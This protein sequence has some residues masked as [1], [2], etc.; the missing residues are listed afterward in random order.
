MSKKT[1]AFEVALQELEH[2]AGIMGLSD[3]V[4]GYLSTPQ[5]IMIVNIPVRMDNGGMKFF[6]GYRAQHNSA[7]GPVKGGT[8]FHHEETLDDVKALS[9]WMTI[10]NSLANIPAGGAKGGVAVDPSTLS[11]G[12]LERLCRGY[13][14]AVF[15]M[16]SPK[17]DIPGP[18][19]GTPQQ[20][21]AWFL[22]EYETLAH[23]HEPA[24]F[25]G[26]PPLLGGSLGRD[27]ATGRGLVYSTGELM[28]QLGTSLAGKRVVIQGFGNLGSHA[29]RFFAEAGAVIIAA[30]DVRG[31]VYAPKGID[32]DK[33]F[34]YLAEHRTIAGLPGTDAISNEELLELECDI[35]APCALQNQ[36]T[37][38]NAARIRA[39]YVVEGANGPTT[40]AAEKLLTENG[41]VVLPDIVANV[42]G[43][44][45]AYFE[46]VQDLYYYFWT[47]GE[48]FNRLETI[49]TKTCQEVYAT[50]RDKKVTM[51][52]AAW[53]ISLDRVVRAMRL[54]SWVR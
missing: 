52:T 4:V 49:M 37:E 25:A 35:L 44:V 30:S 41:V 11:A 45:V 43:A 2:V 3:E 24:T 50:A 6:T 32:I 33:A 38:E 8:R 39:R 19:I 42:G 51:R 14:R 18:D 48:V 29:A 15:P 16:L 47:E 36:I 46:L 28:R 17:V 5:R 23:G 7:L 27:R 31:G 10:K 20:V 21:M 1:S 12:E 54:R 9:F 22:D 53:M 26:K 40:P 34:E 13:I